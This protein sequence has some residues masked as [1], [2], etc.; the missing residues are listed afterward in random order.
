M[1]GREVD[2]APVPLNQSLWLQNVPTSAG[3]GRSKTPSHSNGTTKENESPEVH[4]L[5]KAAGE[6]AKLF[7]RL[8]IP[9]GSTSGKVRARLTK[10]RQF[11]VYFLFPS[12]EDAGLHQ[13]R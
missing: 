9:V 1:R 5:L 3:D 6:R 2:N 12:F 10:Q 13:A 11:R 8:E 4:A 7:A